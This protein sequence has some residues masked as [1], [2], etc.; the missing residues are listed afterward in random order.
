VD[1]IRLESKAPLTGIA[2]THGFGERREKFERLYRIVTLVPI[3][4]RRCPLVA[5]LSTEGIWL[6]ADFFF[7]GSEAEFVERLDRDHPSGIFRQEYLAALEFFKIQRAL[8]I[9]WNEPS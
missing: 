1:S 7:F 8:L 3:G 4:P 9:Q 6:S 2:I 5:Y